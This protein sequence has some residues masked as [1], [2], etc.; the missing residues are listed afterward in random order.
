MTNA[1]RWLALFVVLAGVAAGYYYW[2]LREEPPLPPPAPA[3]APAPP[4][5]AAP[6]P[7]VRYP[8]ETPPAAAQEPPLPALDKSDGAMS[9]ALTALLGR[10]SVAQFL[11]LDGMIRRIVATVDNLPRKQ[12]PARLMPLKRV[13]GPFVTA[14]SGSDRIISPGNAARYA[15]YVRLAQAVDAR[16][17]VGIYVRF[18]ALFQRA[19]EELG[20]PKR[21]FNDRLVEAIDDLLAAPEIAGDI[22]LVQPEVL[23][24]FADPELEARSAGQKILIRMGSE[25]AA[26]VKAKLREIRREV[27]RQAPPR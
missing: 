26:Q 24:A 23:Y 2:Q 13:P 3:E 9:E 12:V 1:M 18:Y 19:Y 6:E 5:P 10:T 4:A 14:P 16:K 20:Y 17:L 7:A 11:H 25:N 15:P 27:T 8:L 21:Y 22:G